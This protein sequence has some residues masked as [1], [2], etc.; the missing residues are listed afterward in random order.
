MKTEEKKRMLLPRCA[1]PLVKAWGLIFVKK[2]E[3]F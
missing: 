1:G 2:E 3:Y